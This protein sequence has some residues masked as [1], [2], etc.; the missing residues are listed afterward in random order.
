MIKIAVEVQQGSAFNTD[1]V[2][3]GGEMYRRIL[4]PLDGSALAEGALPHAMA[5]AKE[6]YSELVLIQVHEPILGGRSGALEAERKIR[7]EAQSYLD[8]IVRRVRKREIS[9]RSL[10]VAGAPAREILSF[11]KKQQIDLIVMSKRGQS[12]VTRWLMGGVADRVARGANVP[13]LLIRDSGE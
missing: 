3:S 12:G 8:R 7:H 6:G 9:A 4:I 1:R 11:P 2:L 10:I 5:L 13:V